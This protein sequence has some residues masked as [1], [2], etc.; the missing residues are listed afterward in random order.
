MVGFEFFDS[1][2]VVERERRVGSEWNNPPSRRLQLWVDQPLA[3]E[4]FGIVFRRFHGLKGKSSELKNLPLLMLNW[5]PPARL[6]SSLR[7]SRFATVSRKVCREIEAP[8]PVEPYLCILS[9]VSCTAYDIRVSLNR[10]FAQ[11]R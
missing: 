10:V 6:H 2:A 11:E 4:P 5:Y 1:T 8:L 9:P 7:P 3:C